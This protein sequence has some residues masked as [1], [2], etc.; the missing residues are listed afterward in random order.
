MGTLSQG[1]GQLF[2]FQHFPPCWKHCLSLMGGGV[3]AS[4]EL[5]WLSL[6]GGEW[7]EVQVESDSEL[8]F[9]WL[10]GV[11]MM[12]DKDLVCQ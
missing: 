10:L 4:P 2:G 5:L 12:I 6:G 9:V 7:R 11:V 3:L 1:A 8:G